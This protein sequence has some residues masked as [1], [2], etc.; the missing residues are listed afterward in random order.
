[1]RD[2]DERPGGEHASRAAIER[3]AV[4]IRRSLILRWSVILSLGSKKP[5]HSRARLG[6]DEDLG[7]GHRHEAVESLAALLDTRSQQRAFIG[8]EQK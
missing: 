7:K 2:E 3:G 5:G 1:M 8:I 6:S 4:V